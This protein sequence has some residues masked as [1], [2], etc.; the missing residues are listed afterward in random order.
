MSESQ[1]NPATQQR[2]DRPTGRL[3][4]TA[5]TTAERP[6]EETAPGTE[7]GQA[8][9]TPAAAERAQE[10][11]RPGRMTPTD[12]TTTAE[13]AI[14]QMRDRWQRAEAEIDNARKRYERQR[15][16]DWRAERARVAAE[17]L[18]VL[19]NLELALGHA[20]ADPQA[21]AQGV[22]AIRQQA[23]D[24]LRRLGFNRLDEVGV[25]FD[26]SRHEA[27]RVVDARDAVP[28]TVV[29][30]IRPGYAALDVLLRPAV[31]AVAGKQ[32]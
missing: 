14:A 13:Q 20:A 31:V 12:E 23:V 29:E 21:I 24:V 22:E 17:W 3:E 6:L 27:V 32:E 26:P 4:Q 19:D 25:P 16:D 11:Q 18:P 10:G 30:V 1:P 28:G 2:Q 15:A 5:T 9:G 8:A 7:T